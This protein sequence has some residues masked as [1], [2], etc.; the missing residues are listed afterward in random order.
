MLKKTAAVMIAAFGVMYGLTIQDCIGSEKLLLT[1]KRKD[2][3]MQKKTYLPDDEHMTVQLCGKELRLLSRFSENKNILL[4]F[5][6]GNMIAAFLDTDKDISQIDEA[7]DFHRGWDDLAPWVFGDYEM[8]GANHG[9]IFAFRVHSV[10]HWCFSEDIG[11]VFVDEAGNEFVLMAVENL[12][13]LVFHSRAVLTDG[14][15]KFAKSIR[16]NLKTADKRQIRVETFKRIQLPNHDRR[17]QTVHNRYNSVKIF[18]DGKLLEPGRIVRCSEVKMVLDMDLCP[19]DALCEYLV[20]NPGKYIA[21]NAPELESLI[22]MTLVYTFQSNNT[23]QAD[24]EIEFRRDINQNILY[25]LLQ[26]YGEKFFAVH[27]KFVPGLKPF[28]RADFYT[29]PDFAVHH[30][31]FLR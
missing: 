25:G 24:A 26:Y 19:P 29:Y 16:G 6:E 9:S 28:V 30:A 1:G 8:I 20:K 11:K 4:R 27:E 2:L 12:A 22:N 18:A 5:I 7:V 10:R 17:V 3:S 31:A 14:R 13:E 15:I 21:P 23:M